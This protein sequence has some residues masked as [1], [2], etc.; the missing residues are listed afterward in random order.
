MNTKIALSGLS[1]FAALA[2]IGGA[3]FA[4]FSDSGTSTGNVFGSGTVDLKLGNGV[5]ATSDSVTG[6][7]GASN[8][9][10]N[11]ATVSATLNLKNTGTIVANHVDIIVTDV[12]TQAGS[13]P[14][15]VSTNPMDK[16]LKLTTLTYDAVDLLP[17]IAESNGN[18]FK[19]LED[20]KNNNL[21]AGDLQNLALADTGVDH[22]LV[23][24]VQ[25]DGTAPNDVQGDSVDVTLTITLD[26]GPTH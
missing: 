2:L 22:P 16:Y 19:D 8:M 15:N 7:I 23:I 18:G 20:L 6:T 25:L 21:T 12:L 11:G 4:F 1:I 9:V 26:Q 14:G 10:P 17:S 24:G 3:T 5:T 13:P